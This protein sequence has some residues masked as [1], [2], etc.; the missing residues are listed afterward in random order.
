[1]QVKVWVSVAAAVVTSL[2]LWGVIIATTIWSWTKLTNAQPDGL[3]ALLLLGGG[4]VILLTGVWLV[5]TAKRAIE[6]EAFMPLLQSGRYV[7]AVGALVLSAGAGSLLT[8]EVA[9]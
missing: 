6:T 8:I 1:M 2:L 7:V 3:L 9:R 5:G 4:G